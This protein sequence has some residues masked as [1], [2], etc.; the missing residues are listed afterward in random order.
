[1][2]TL[3][4]VSQLACR[5][6][7]VGPRYAQVLNGPEVPRDVAATIRPPTADCLL[8][9]RQSL[10]DPSDLVSGPLP[11]KLHA[12]YAEVLRSLHPKAKQVLRRTHGVWFARKIPGAAARFVPCVNDGQPSGLVLVDIQSNPLD[13]DGVRDVEVPT[14]YWQLL[15]GSA[16]PVPS[17]E[18][19]RHARADHPAVRYVILHEL[20]HALSLLAGEF[21]LSPGLEFQLPLWDGFYAFS[22]Q[23]R[24]RSAELD[25]IGRYGGLIPTHLSLRDWMRLRRQLHATATWLAPGY[26]QPNRLMPSAS[27]R[28]LQELPRAGFVTPTAVSAPTEDYAEIFSHAILAAEGKI[29]PEDESEVTLPG[30]APQTIAAPYF[31]SGVSAKRAYIERQLD[32]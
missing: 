11:P 22:W 27:C 26:E 21:T 3:L 24:D 12:G 20:G 23:A 25:E 17:P 2:L 29:H 18:S 4:A 31:A 7:G 10:E 8:R 28:V 13:A 15:G 5:A 6:G 1:L 19:E 32:L 9:A 14:R 30:C 16:L